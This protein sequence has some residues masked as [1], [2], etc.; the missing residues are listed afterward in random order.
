M[1]S[2]S[3]TRDLRALLDDGSVLNAAE[4][5]ERYERGYRY[6]RGTALAIALPRSPEQVA[7]IVRY[8]YRNDIPLVAQGANTG[9]VAGSTPDSSGEQIVL[10]LERLHGIESIEP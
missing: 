4:E 8:C 3:V 2:E 6:G 1:R 10:S 5:R 9:L 7:D